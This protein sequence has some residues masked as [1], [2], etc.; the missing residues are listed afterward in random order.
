M[1]K[2]RELKAEEIKCRV[3]R[4]TASGLQL[5]LYK[6]ARV[7]MAILDE[8][9]GIARWQR[10][11]YVVDG[12]VYCRVGI[13]IDNEWIWKSDCGVESFADGEKGESSDSFKRACVN[14]G[15]GRSLYTAPF[16]WVKKADYNTN[17][18]GKCADSFSVLAIDIQDGFIKG[19]QVKN[20]KSGN[21]VYTFG[22]LRNGMRKPPEAPKP[23]A[24][25]APTAQVPFPEIEQPKPEDKE[26]N[27]PLPNISFDEA[28]TVEFEGVLLTD[29]FKT[30][31]AAFM[32][33]LNECSDPRIRAAAIVLYNAVIAAQKK[34]EA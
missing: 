25:T 3:A 12:V 21:T 5:L 11:H 2:F 29:L 8:T 10:E 31:R 14:F 18:K 1:C 28:K 23:I 15:I 20:D 33:V 34:K 17:D 9:V 30:N 27:F 32:C 13:K 16:I 22:T 6:D 24:P 19:L 7:D 4:E 26:K